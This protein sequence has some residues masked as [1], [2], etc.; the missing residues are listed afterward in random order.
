ML[1]ERTYDQVSQSRAALLAPGVRFVEE[2]IQNIALSD[3]TVFAGRESPTWDFLV[4]ALG[5]DLNL[6]QC[7][8]WQKPHILF[9]R[10]RARNG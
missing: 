7:R 3:R 6:P 9:I 5:A 8:G 1:G 10:S 2:E 4:I